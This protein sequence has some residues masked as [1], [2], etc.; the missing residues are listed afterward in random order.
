MPLLH[1]LSELLETV[2]THW[3]TAGLANLLAIL[4][5]LCQDLNP[6]TTVLLRLSLVIR[7]VTPP[8]PQLTE[9]LAIALIH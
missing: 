4:D 3:S 6:V 9:L 2:P 1:Q 5:T 8:L 7:V